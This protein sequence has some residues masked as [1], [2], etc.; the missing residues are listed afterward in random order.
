MNKSPTTATTLPLAWLIVV[1]GCGHSDMPMREPRLICFT[2]N[3]HNLLPRISEIATRF[4][5]TSV[6]PGD[7]LLIVDSERRTLLDST[8]RDPEFLEPLSDIQRLYKREIESNIA[9][10]ESSII[11]TGEGDPNQFGQGHLLLHIQREFSGL[12][13][14]NK[15]IIMVSDGFDSYPS[16]DKEDLA[17]YGAEEVIEDLSHRN[18]I[19]DLKEFRIFRTGPVTSDI[20]LSRIY[21]QFWDSLFRQAQAKEIRFIGWESATSELIEN[22]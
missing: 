3:D 4:A 20:N 9:G 10:I 7:R 5:S 11:G 16:V 2:I 12:S 1:T 8:V 21:D 19:P 14:S 17:L 13:V 18:L 15:I 6:V 22:I